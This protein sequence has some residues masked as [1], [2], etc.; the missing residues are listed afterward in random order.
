MDFNPVKNCSSLKVVICLLFVKT[1]PISVTAA[2]SSYDNSP[3]PSVSQFSIQIDF[4]TGSANTMKAF[5]ISI[6]SGVIL[7]SLFLSMAML[8]LVDFSKCLSSASVIEIVKPLLNVIGGTTNQNCMLLSPVVPSWIGVSQE[9][10]I[11]SVASEAIVTDGT[12]SSGMVT[13]AFPASFSPLFPFN[14]IDLTDT[15]SPYN[16]SIK[17]PPTFLN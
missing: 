14:V 11:S 17:Y 13:D 8:L 5:F 10:V 9:R 1:S 15:P 3:S 12:P 4:T 6:S 16:L 7:A 2:A